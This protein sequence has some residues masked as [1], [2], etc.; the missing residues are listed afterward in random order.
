MNAP[1]TRNAAVGFEPNISA[2]PSFVSGG[3]TY[4]FASWSDGEERSHVI[5]FPRPT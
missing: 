4:E 2:A 1:F 3:T 5:R